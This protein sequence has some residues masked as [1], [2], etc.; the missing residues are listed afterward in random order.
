MPNWCSSWSRWAIVLPDLI[1][2]TAVDSV[3][4]D[5]DGTLLDL[6]FDNHFWLEHVPEKY[7]GKHNIALD[8]ARRV[9]EEKYQA[10]VGTLNWYC[11]DYWSDALALD[12]AELKREIDH[13]IAFRPGV[14]DF[15]LALKASDKRAVLV[16]NAHQKSLSLKIE[17]TG[18]DRYFDAL[19]CSH[20]LG[21]PKEAPAFWDALDKA[22]PY[23]P[24][25]TLLIDDSAS[26]LESAQRAGI[27]YLLSIAQPDSRQ[28]PRAAGAF[29]AVSD[30]SE[31]LLIE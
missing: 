5:M 3:F 14:E 21:M 1:D 31:L 15:L 2:W 17:N 28:A 29:P 7:A 26:V 16:T 13:L 6:H 12:I 22:E 30:F 24:E 23:Q 25:R 9:L 8:E 11:I 27:R 20:D 18:L 10:I 19:I 4:L